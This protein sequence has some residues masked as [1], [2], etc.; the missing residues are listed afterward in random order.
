MNEL[1]VK[2]PSLHPEQRRTDAEAQRFSVWDCGRRFGK[3]VMSRRRLLRVAAPGKPVAYFAPTYK[4]LSEY[5]RETALELFPII[6]KPNV[7]E[8]GCN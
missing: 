5:W 8:S 2:V 1:R 6:D 7:Q 4:M 3:S